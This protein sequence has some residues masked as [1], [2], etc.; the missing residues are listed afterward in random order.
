MDHLLQEIGWRI[1]KKRDDLGISREQFSEIIGIT[2]HF[3][4]QIE[5]GKKGMSTYTLHKICSGLNAS[6]DYI[7]MGR[8]T[9]NDT[10]KLNALLENVDPEYL[11]YIEEVVKSLILVLSKKK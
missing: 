3:L 9:K 4:A 2:P 8:E 6:A 11:P 10:S 1:R 7:L 5:C